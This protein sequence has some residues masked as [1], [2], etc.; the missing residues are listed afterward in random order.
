MARAASATTATTPTTMRSLARE[1][2]ARRDAWRTTASVLLVQGNTA[3]QG[4]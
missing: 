1:L 4:T 2:E 3:H